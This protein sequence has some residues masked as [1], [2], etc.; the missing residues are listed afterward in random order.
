M[1]DGDYDDDVD[2]DGGDDE[3]QYA[4]VQ[5][6]G[7][8]VE[9]TYVRMVEHLH[10]PHFSEQLKANKHFHFRYHNYYY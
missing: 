5:R 10:Y 3:H 8:S 7:E 4:L 2:D 9:L 6:K 1:D